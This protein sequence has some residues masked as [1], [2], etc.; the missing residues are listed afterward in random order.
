MSLFSRAVSRTPDMWST[1][2]PWPRL[3]TAEQV[4]E[5]IGVR[6]DRTG[7]IG[8]VISEADILRRMALPRDPVASTDD[9]TVTLA[10]WESPTPRWRGGIGQV[11]GLTGFEV[12]Y[13]VEKQTA[14]ARVRTAAPLPVHEIANALIPVFTPNTPFA[15]TG[16]PLVGVAAGAGD[17][18]LALLPTRTVPPVEPI[19]ERLQGVDLRRADV[20]LGGSRIATEDLA[21]HHLSVRDAA[22]TL[23][24]TQRAAIDLAVHNPIGRELVFKP[25]RPSARMTTDGRTA[26]LAP[27][28]QDGAI[29]FAL[30]RALPAAVVRRLRGLEDIDLSGLTSLPEGL[31]ARFAEIAATDTILHSLPDAVRI[32][33]EALSSRITD[34]MRR[35][36][37]QQMG[38]ERERR[39]VEL[40]RAAMAEHAGYLRLAESVRD[41]TGYRYLPKVSVIL[42][43]MRRELIPGV[44]EMMAKQTYAEMEVVVVVHGVPAPDLDGA[45]IGDLDYRIVEVPGTVL[46]GAAL[47][48]GVRQSTGDLITK[49]DD[50][51]WY[52][53]HHVSDLVLAH[54]YS[55]A[56]IVGKTTEYLFF[57]EVNQTV[58]RTF[59]T[60]RY[61]D[62]VAGGTMLLSRAAFD[63]LGGWRPTPNSTDRSVLIRVE[64][65]GGVAYRTQSLGYMYIRHASKHTWERTASQLVEG[66]FEQWRGWREPEV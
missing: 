27:S 39:A 21:T 30:D 24:R 51:D 62:Q 46:F 15:G 55:R 41:T 42:S 13:D 66:S 29:D 61:H 8:L 33:G 45:D 64:T 28:T 19:V 56:D 50:D 7:P 3:D 11:R 47:A 44:L 12:A 26:R 10:N 25:S 43:T 35:P 37:R 54:L 53:E 20:V 40:R 5:A 34:A 36:Y 49:L 32:P 63:A 38:L 9:L 59:A 57:E 22:Y 48:E 14:S 17:D 6:S 52:S 1:S 4:A 18:V 58:H 16:F 65:Q 2:G 31:A 23:P 60:E